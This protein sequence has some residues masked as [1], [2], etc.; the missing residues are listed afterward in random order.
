MEEI[1][2]PPIASI[3]LAKDFQGNLRGSSVI[4]LQNLFVR[5]LMPLR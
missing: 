4:A 2:S 5:W 3:A 1:E